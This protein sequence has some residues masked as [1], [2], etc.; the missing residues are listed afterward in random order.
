MRTIWFTRYPKI[1]RT[2]Y[3]D[4]IFRTRRTQA[5]ETSDKEQQKIGKKLD[6]M[7]LEDLPEYI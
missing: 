2:Q 1:Y 4:I 7:N 5:M 6:P 3:Q